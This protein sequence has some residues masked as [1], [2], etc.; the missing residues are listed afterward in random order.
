MWVDRGGVEGVGVAFADLHAPV[1]E[2]K[3]LGGDDEAILVKSISRNEEVG[4]AGLIFEGDEAVSLGRAGALAADDLAG[5]CDV[6]AVGDVGEVDGAES[7]RAWRPRRAAG[8]SFF[9][10]TRTT[11]PVVPTAVIVSSPERHGVGAGCVALG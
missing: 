5:G 3:S 10:G 7:G 8:V 9:P 1:T 6:L 11:G 2:E 4:D